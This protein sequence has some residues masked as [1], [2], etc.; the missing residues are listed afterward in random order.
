LWRQKEQF[1]DGARRDIRR[2][3]AEISAR[4]TAKVHQRVSSLRLWQVGYSWID[5]LKA[6]AEEVISDD[7]M[8]TASVRRRDRAEIARRSRADRAA[9]IL[10]RFW[11]QS[12]S[13]SHLDH[14]QRIVNTLM[15]CAFPNQVP[16]Q[17]AE[18]QGGLLL[19]HYLPLALPQQQLRQRHRGHRAR[20]DLRAISERSTRDLGAISA[21]PLQAG[22]RSRARLRRPSSGTP[23]SPTPRVRC[24]VVRILSALSHAPPGMCA[25]FLGS[26]RVKALLLLSRAG[27]VGPVRERP[28]GR[29]RLSAPRVT[30]AAPTRIIARPEVAEPHT[31][32]APDLDSLIRR[33]AH[34]SKHQRCGACARR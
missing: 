14:R 7:D 4:S 3:I 33:P 30:R 10:L 27:P 12:R 13:A 16:V 34:I 20:H 6:H 1:S 2:E 22:R 25:S 15:N 8:A 19:P 11:P 23:R 5:G 21:S 18:G 9:R 31:G 32:R 26:A 17:H 28:R 24:A 29:G